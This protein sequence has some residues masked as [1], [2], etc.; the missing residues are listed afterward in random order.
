MTR[1]PQTQTTRLQNIY[2]YTSLG[3]IGLSILL[4]LLGI[5]FTRTATPAPEALVSLAVIYLQYHYAHVII[6]IALLIFYAIQKK[7]YIFKLNVLKTIFGILFSPIS[8][9]ILTTAILLLG[10]S[11]CASGS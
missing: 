10:L 11:S 9:I 8:Y 2:F 5:L 1:E 3:M 4:F 7:K 6:G